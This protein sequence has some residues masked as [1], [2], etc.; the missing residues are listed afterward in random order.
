MK[1]LVMG[2][3]RRQPEINQHFYCPESLSTAEDVEN[4]NQK[5]GG[6]HTQDMSGLRRKL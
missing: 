1:S 2:G 5:C 6:P 4:E 3:L